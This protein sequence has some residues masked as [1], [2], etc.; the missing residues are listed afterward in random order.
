MYDRRIENSG[1]QVEQGLRAR[2]PVRCF[3]GEIRQA[4]SNLVSNAIDAMPLSGGRLQ[5]RSRDAV[6]LKTGREGVVLTI[7][8][9]GEGI[10]RSAIH[11]ILDAFYTTKDLGGTGLGPWVSEPPWRRPPR[12]Q[13]TIR[14]PK[15]DSV[16]ALSPARLRGS[17]TGLLLL[18]QV[19]PT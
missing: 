6:N 18:P 2:R 1:I 8:D 3:E 16:Y 15:L 13:C 10:P 12:P 19:D 5:I 14:N 9:N 7:A 11:L 4:L 17:V